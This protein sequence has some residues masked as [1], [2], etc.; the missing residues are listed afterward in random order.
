MKKSSLLLMLQLAYLALLFLAA[1]LVL[2]VRGV[3][4]LAMGVV[5]WFVERAMDVR[6]IVRFILVARGIL[7]RRR[8]ERR[9]PR[10][11]ETV[12]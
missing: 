9:K 4:F 1:G 5:H 2:A 12:H 7:R 11:D 3:F 6:A 8:A 10:V